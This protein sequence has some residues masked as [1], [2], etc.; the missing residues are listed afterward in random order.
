MWALMMLIAIVV[1]GTLA[2]SLVLF[3]LTIHL[4]ELKNDKK[5]VFVTKDNKVKSVR[6]HFSPLNF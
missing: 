2:H 6:S 3:E 5:I 4:M 1:V